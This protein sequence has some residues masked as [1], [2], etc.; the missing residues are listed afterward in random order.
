MHATVEPRSL[1]CNTEVAAVSGHA[2]IAAFSES[3]A[4]RSPR[5]RY[6]GYKRDTRLCRSSLCDSVGAAAV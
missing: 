3:S 6:S 1:P 5:V 2:T 4:N